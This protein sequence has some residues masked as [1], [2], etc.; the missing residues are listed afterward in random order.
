MMELKLIVLKIQTYFSANQ[1][2]GSENL[3]IQGFNLPYDSEYSA[4]EGL[5]PWVVE[6]KIKNVSDL[7][8]VFGLNEFLY[9]VL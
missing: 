2:D 9:S 4:L 6:N 3:I 7:A 1:Q 5:L 8:N